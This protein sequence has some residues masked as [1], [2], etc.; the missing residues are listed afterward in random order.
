[1]DH[2]LRNR[3]VGKWWQINKYTHQFVRQFKT[4][5]HTLI[6]YYQWQYLYS[7]I[8]ILLL[9][10]WI[11]LWQALITH[12]T[13]FSITLA[14][15][16]EMRSSRWLSHQPL[17]YLTISWMLVSLSKTL[18]RAS[19]RSDAILLLSQ[20]MTLW[21]PISTYRL[22][23]TDVSAHTAPRHNWYCLQSKPQ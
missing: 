10:P 15:N 12:H 14:S 3:L 1:M 2:I 19:T 21:S 17:P 23:H 6:V 8:S 13:S 22:W 9:H 16:P 11:S 5:C 4:L 18:T 20:G 7:A